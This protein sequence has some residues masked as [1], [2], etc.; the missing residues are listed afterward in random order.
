MVHKKTNKM[1]HK[2]TNNGPQK[3]KQFCLFVDHF[4]CLF[5][6][7]CLFFCGSLLPM[8]HKKTNNGPQKDKQ[9]STNRQ[10]MVHKKLH[11]K[12][13]ATRTPQKTMVNVCLFVDHCLS[14]CGP[15]YLSFCGPLFVFLWIIV[16]VFVDHCLSFCGS[17]FVFLWTIDKHRNPTR[18]PG[19]GSWKH[20]IK[21][22]E[23]RKTKYTTH[24]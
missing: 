5:V 9:W 22:T 18:Q 2:K 14:F 15:F 4:I 7:H 20:W 1:V 19:M 12:L 8:V 3:D 17:L 24:T 16:C 21:Y 23:R 6:D 11:R 13:R 10:T